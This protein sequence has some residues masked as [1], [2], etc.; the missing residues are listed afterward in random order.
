MSADRA[1][2][3]DQAPLETI[4]STSGPGKG[5]GNERGGNRAPGLNSV[6]GSV[7]TVRHPFRGALF[8]GSRSRG[9][10]YPCILDL[11]A[12]RTPGYS[13]RRLRRPEPTR[14][15]AEGRRGVGGGGTSRQIVLR[16]I[17]RTLRLFLAFSR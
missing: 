17:T 12:W 11:R 3:H 7:S 13:P 2:S 6:I 1:C 9:A 5:C 15:S 10:G 8:S 14:S 4:V 16:L